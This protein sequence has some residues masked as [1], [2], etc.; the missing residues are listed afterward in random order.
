[1]AKLTTSQDISEFLDTANK[2]EAVDVLEAV[3]TENLVAS[4]LIVQANDTVKGYLGNIAN[5]AFESQSGLKGLSLGSSVTTIGSNAF[6]YC[7]GLTGSLNIPDSVTTIGSSAFEY[8]TGFNGPLTIG[9]SVTTIAGSA[10]G[11]C[12]GFT[13]TLNIPSSVT[14]IGA[15]AFQNCS[16]FTRININRFT[17][18][19]I[20]TNAFQNMTGVSPAVIHVP[21]GATGYAASYNGLTIVKDL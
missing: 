10:F 8:C 16:G 3:K 19:T 21:V 14:T 1:M 13:G 12:A 6:Y 17:A 2:A 4:T 7:G 15:T 5:N 18:P 11:Y 20:G 9:N